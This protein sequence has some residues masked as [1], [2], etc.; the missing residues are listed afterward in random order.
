MGPLASH[1]GE[2]VPRQ[3]ADVPRCIHDSVERITRPIPE[4]EI[5][6]GSRFTLYNKVLDKTIRLL[7]AYRRGIEQ[8][9]ACPPV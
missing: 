9:I 1:Q 7:L 8:S 4:E 3:R 2:H 6:L 5:D